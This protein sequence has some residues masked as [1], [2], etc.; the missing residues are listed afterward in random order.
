MWE[1]ISNLWEAYGPNMDTLITILIVIAMP[2]LLWRAGGD[3]VWSRLSS[4]AAKAKF[5]L[6][7]VKTATPDDAFETLMV[8]VDQL[9][10]DKDFDLAGDAL[11]L[12]QRKSEVTAPV[13][14]AEIVPN[15]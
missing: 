6:P 10:H 2:F 15:G 4:V 9:G 3:L 12:A 1:I 14:P 5:K 11:K 7:G 8:A 13:Q